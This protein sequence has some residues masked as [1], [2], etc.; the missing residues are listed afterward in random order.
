M[1]PRLIV[2]RA[3]ALLLTLVL[4]C[5]L[6]TWPGT[7]YDAVRRPVLLL[8]LAALWA[9]GAVRLARLREERAGRDPL[10]TAGL[11]LGCVSGLSWAAAGGRGEWV[12]PLLALAAG[13]GVYGAVRRGPLPEEFPAESAPRV[14]AL[15]SV[16]LGLWG[17][18]QALRGESAVAGEGN[19]NYSGAVSALLLPACLGT[20]LGTRFKT[21]GVAGAVAAL[22]LLA[23][24]ESRGGWVGSVAGLGVFTL[25]SRRW[26]A[27]LL[28][29]AV[30]LVLPFAGRGRDPL[31]DSRMETAGVRAG[32]WKGALAILREHPLLG[33]GPGTFPSEYPAHRDPG[34]FRLS[35]RHTRRSEFVE[36]EDAHSS[37][38][39]AAA[40]TGVPGLLA[41]GL[42]A[43][44]AARR[45]WFHSRNGAER[46]VLIAGYGGAAAA[47]LAAGV[48]N[49]LTLHL[50]PLVLFW[51]CLG[52]A[53]REGLS[54]LVVRRR[55]AGQGAVA[56]RAAGAALLA[57][58][59]LPAW[60]LLHRDRLFSE[61]MSRSAAA[62]R[63]ALLEEIPGELPGMARVHLA[64][65]EAFKGLGRPA[66]AV[67]AYRAVLRERPH[68]AAALN[69]LGASL[70]LARG[71]AEE[72]ERSVRRAREL[73]PDWFY[74][75][76]ILGGM[77]I[78]SGDLR[79][80]ERQLEAACALDPAHAGARFSRGEVRWRS[81]RRDEAREDFRKARELGLDVGAAIRQEH[82][83]WEKD[84][85]LAEFFP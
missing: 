9:L 54:A 11:L 6:Y 44:V 82:P 50:S 5:P 43:L 12:E 78:L 7:G 65:A 79:G 73:A 69:N 24:S 23:L 4:A 31:S 70:V 76:Y 8:L 15:L 40:E 49:T 52:L 29:F 77:Q 68:Q 27:A 14:L 21:A 63:L 17:G 33:S 67:E 51:A 57:F 38:M 25:L 53:D 41:W 56:L 22:L 37:W 55:E 71:S 18:L 26:R 28:V 85:L 19:T 45:L 84:A 32:L 16:I 36:P 1:D 35:H 10:L 39:Q 30:L 83:E 2:R 62:E 58:A 20:A 60:A 66:E 48:F 74:P 3:A 59:V 61:A 72:A 34:E 47:F 42:L 75:A 64:R 80:A 81:G 13:L 46:T